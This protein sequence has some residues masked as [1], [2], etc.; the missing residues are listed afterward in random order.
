MDA[1]VAAATAWGHA[2][3]AVLRLSG[4]DALAVARIVCPGGPAW[5]SR[6]VCL[7]PALA[8]GVV[9]DDVLAV[10]MPGPKSYTGEDVVELSCHGNPVIVELLLDAA[11]AAGARPAREGEFTRRA[12]L[13]GRMDLLRAEAVAGL[14][15][16]SSAEGV[17]LARA[18]LAGR[19]S[20]VCEA[21]RERL[22]DLTAELEARFDSPGEELAYEEDAVV[23]AGV[24]DLAAT[25]RAAADT[26]RAGRARIHGARVALIGP[27][28]AGKSSLFN[29][30][31]GERR[32]LV[33][34]IPGTTRDVVERAMLVDGLEITLLD[35]AGDREDAAGLEAEGQALARAL[36]ADVDLLLLVLPLHAPQSAVEALFARAEGRPTLV[37]G[38]HLDQASG[39]DQAPGQIYPRVDYCVDNLSGQGIPALKAAIR[40]RVAADPPS[41][42]MVVV[43]SQRQHE[44][45]RAVAEHAE[46]SA[47]ALLGDAGPVVA[48]EELTAALARLAELT[49]EDTR[50]A[51]LDR[52]FARFCIGK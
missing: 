15:Q 11:V 18:G 28:N 52:V 41:G 27:V 29:A 47:R 23:A 34:P 13:N 45:L 7:R 10:W 35:T 32:A 39:L 33:S 6:R 37:V 16:A 30:L 24:A 48:A 46:E 20:A 5:R 49:G 31:L 3:I 22:L 8:A 51:V 44:L 50:E 25:A 26:W 43:V 19:T 40:A 4:P 12:L 2:A 36:T 17:A 14:I 42:A 38:T 1:V 9:V 21:L